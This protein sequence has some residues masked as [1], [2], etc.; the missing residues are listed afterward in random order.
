MVVGSVSMLE[1]QRALAAAAGGKGTTV[2]LPGN[3]PMATGGAAPRT[4]SGSGSSTLASGPA[5]TPPP[6]LVPASTPGG[7]PATTTTVTGVPVP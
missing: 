7:Q 4:G 1:V 6:R 2:P 5:A 3:A